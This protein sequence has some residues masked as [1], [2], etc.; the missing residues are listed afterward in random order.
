VI[1]VR[2]MM[3][4]PTRW[5]TLHQIIA[6]CLAIGLIVLSYAVGFP[7]VGAVLILSGLYVAVWMF[8]RSGVFSTSWLERHTSSSVKHAARLEFAKAMICAGIG[9]DGILALLW[10]RGYIPRNDLTNVVL[11]TWLMLTV[12]GIGLFLTRWFAAYLMTR[13]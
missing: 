3:R 8:L 12:V 6:V 2:P 13:R 4:Q 11:I 7:N 10:G 5:A 1:R 9:I